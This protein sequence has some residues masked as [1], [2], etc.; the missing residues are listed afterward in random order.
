MEHYIPILRQTRLFAGV[1]EEEI[2][3]MLHCLQ[4]RT[5]SYK[6]G[7]YIFRQGDCLDT[8]SVPLEYF[9]AITYKQQSFSIHLQ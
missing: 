1:S 3:S 4:S 2:S 7:E 8:I 6:K 9:I 5:L